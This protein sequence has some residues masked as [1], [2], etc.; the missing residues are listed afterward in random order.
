MPFIKESKP[1][2]SAYDD[3]L[4]VYFAWGL[5]SL[6][7]KDY[8][9]CTTKQIIIIDRELFG[10]T[11]N[12]K[13]FYYEDI[14]SA[15]V[16]QNSNSSDLTGMLIDAA[17]TAATQT[18]NL[19]ISVAGSINKISTLTKVEA[20]RVVAVYHQYRK[21]AKQTNSQPQVIVQQQTE[22]PVEQ[23]KKLKELADLGII[24]EEEF[25]QKKADLLAKI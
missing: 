20:E 3:E 2:L 11:A 24:S 18:C 9:V 21:I 23:I 7:A 14:T 6:S 12:I 17:I 13:Q 8:I 1:Y 16:E 19:I 5:D 10:S 15:S 4:M 25:N 22:N